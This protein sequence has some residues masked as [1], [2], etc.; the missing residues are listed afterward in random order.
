MYIFSFDTF[1]AVL[2]IKINYSSSEIFKKS[3]FTSK[4]IQNYCK[5]IYL[6]TYLTFIIF[7]SHH[8]YIY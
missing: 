5:L 2:A 7:F 8:S 1:Q 3:K 6:F 4:D